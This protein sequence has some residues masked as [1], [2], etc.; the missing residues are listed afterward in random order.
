MGT[1]EALTPEPQPT[2]Q[3]EITSPE[4][5]PRKRYIEKLRA[6]AEHDPR[7]FATRAI[8]AFDAL[9]TEKI[10]QA[11]QDEINNRE[12]FLSHHRILGGLNTAEGIAQGWKLTVKSRESAGFASGLTEAFF[13]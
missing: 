9:L 5:N 7:L 2:N 10:P 13:S 3:Q 4:E 6:L 8:N 11:D 1:P 12:A